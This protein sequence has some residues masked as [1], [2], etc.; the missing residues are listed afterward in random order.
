VSQSDIFSSNTATSGAVAYSSNFL[1]LEFSNVTATKG[2]A[3]TGGVMTLTNG[4]LLVIKDGF[5]ELNEAQSIGGVFY[6]INI[7][8]VSL[9]RLTSNNNIASLDGGCVAA[10][11]GIQ[12]ELL[13]ES[14]IQMR[15]LIENSS[16]TSNTVQRRG[17]AV[18]ANSLSQIFIR[19]TVFK[20]NK[21]L[22]GGAVSTAQSSGNISSSQFID[23][24]ALV[25]GGGV[26]WIY[27]ANGP[28]V[29]PLLS[30]LLRG[31]LNAS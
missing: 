20:N 28:M 29:S 7:G 25:G 18:Y 17:G 21:A 27:Q 16:F 13:D 31:S 22:Y 2:Q 5:F 1:I 19:D 14:Q 9:Q 11:G 23:N 24:I 6:L 3:T 10:Y 12:S 15:L 8:T 4:L 30:F 26:F